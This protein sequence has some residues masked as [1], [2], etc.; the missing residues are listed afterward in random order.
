MADEP[1]TGPGD[2]SDSNDNEGDSPAEA[3]ASN[4]PG[5]PF[6]AFGLGSG[7]PF[8]TEGLGP[9][10]ALDFSQL[11][12]MLQSDGPL[13]WE[14]ARQTAAWVAA[15]DTAATAPTPDAPVDPATR[16][17][18][19]ALVDIAVT[20]VVGATGLSGSFET[21]RDVLGPQAWAH[22]QLDALKPVLEAFATT[23]ERALIEEIQ[24]GETP[25]DLTANPFGFLAGGDPF[26]GIMK[27]L[28]P[29]LLGVQAGS[30]V[31]YLAQHAIG[32][33]DLPLPLDA[34][35]SLVFVAQNLDAFQ[36]SWEL[37]RNDTRLYIALHETVHAAVRSVPWVRERLVNLAIEYVQ[38]YTIDANAM[39]QQFEGLDPTDPSTFAAA[40]ANPIALLGAIRG[41][42]QDDVLDRLR[43]F[44]SVIEGYGDAVLD[45]IGRPLVASF[46]RIHEALARHRLERGE[47]GQFIE[48]LL[49][50][51]LQR[52][53]Y[54]AGR[55][56]ADG[57]VER[58]GLDGL[59]QL[60]DDARR[61]PTPAELSAPGLWLA[62]LEV[63]DD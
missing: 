25:L 22:Q 21:R 40:G 6:G 47:A 50:V 24:S 62:R 42:G 33:Y 46:D 59:N 36:T 39:D 52:E 32:R 10:G 11:G 31:G 63:M 58:A 49:G 3:G 26:G 61:L 35:P 53:H 17:E 45:H 41:P 16:A 29:V 48:G 44:A 60:W 14:I 43:T 56:F 1:Q 19:L 7:M 9:L 55:T 2:S 8:G 23:L 37:D 13:N 30:M 51:D 18:I 15:G 28:A 20:H 27:M 54:E 34:E 4:T 57:V 5:N 38:A 12:A